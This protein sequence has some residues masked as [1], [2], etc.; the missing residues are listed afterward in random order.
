MWTA[1]S[2]DEQ[3]LKT[4]RFLGIPFVIIDRPVGRG[5]GYDLVA[6][7]GEKAAVETVRYLASRGHRKIGF[8]G[9]DSQV[10]SSRVAGFRK[11]V[12]DLGLSG[13]DCPIFLGNLSRDSGRDLAFRCLSQGRVSALFIGHHHI[14]EGAV[15]A[16]SQ[17]GIAVPDDLSVI[18]YGSPTWAEVNCPAYTVVRLPD[19]EIGQQGM[20]M[21][22]KK[23]ENGERSPEQVWLDCELVVRDSVKDMWCGAGTTHLHNE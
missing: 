21:L 20:S 7:D 17:L 13:E 18:I 12:S 19:T 22:L 11:A 16:I 6:Y 4:L 10:V 2:E 23:I 14:G 1:A 9:W 5:S 3:V 15:M 8:I